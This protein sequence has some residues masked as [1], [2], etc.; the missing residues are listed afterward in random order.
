[1]IGADATNTNL[2]RTG[3]TITT[4][5]EWRNVGNIAAHNLQVTGLDNT[6]AYL[7]SSYLSTSSINSG[8]FQNGVFVEEGREEVRVTADIKVTGDAGNVVD[9]SDGILSIQADGSEV[10]SNASKGSANLITFQGDLNYDG[11]VSMKDLA[12]LN[13]G[14][15]RQQYMTAA[16][17]AEED[18]DNNGVLDAS[19]ARDVDA[20]FN[21]KIELADL[22]ILDQDWGKTLHTGDQ[23]FQGSADVS[24][25]DLDT[26]GNTSNWDN[27]SFKDQNAI[28][29][30]STYVGSLESPA[31]TGVIGADGN[32]G[33]DNNNI[34]GDAFQDPL[35]A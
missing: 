11:R 8:S 24:W 33:V 32:E 2:I 23:Q 25:S 5:A 7:D 6:N 10:F 12:Y 18:L 28:E 14:A 15:A 4:T 20:D 13:A 27:S 31:A 30:D 3:D 17:T 26:Q 19:V 9:L 22:S 29:A 16:N 35:A 34:Q 1:M 21:G